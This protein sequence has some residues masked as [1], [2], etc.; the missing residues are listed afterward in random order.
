MRDGWTLS[1]D[2]GPHPSRPS[3]SGSHPRGD[4]WTQDPLTGCPDPRRQDP[5]LNPQNTTLE[6]TAD[7]VRPETETLSAGLTG[8]GVEGRPQGSFPPTRRESVRREKGRRE[9]DGDRLQ[10]SLLVTGRSGPS[11]HW[12]AGEG[13]R[14]EGRTRRG[15]LT[16]VPSLSRPF[17][18]GSR[19]RPIALRDEEPGVHHSSLST[20][21]DF[22]P[23]DLGGGTPVKEVL[24]PGLTWDWDPWRGQKDPRLSSRK[25]TCPPV[26]TNDRN[27]HPYPTIPLPRLVRSS[28]TPES[29]RHGANDPS[30]PPST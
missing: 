6:V 11:R 14:R 8:S 10:R 25:T 24:R 26:P 18:D 2:P 23:E 17:G 27:T 7:D 19:V 29:L 30:L 16:S 4:T 5:H 21:A 15:Q 28:V 20:E 3:P 13:L 22:S 9:V 12:L 1:T